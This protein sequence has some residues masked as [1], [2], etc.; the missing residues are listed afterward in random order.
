[1]AKTDSNGNGAGH[2]SQPRVNFVL[3]GKGGIGR[4]I[5][6]SWLAELLMDREE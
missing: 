2:T 4:S 1:M 3:Q 6:A 5:V